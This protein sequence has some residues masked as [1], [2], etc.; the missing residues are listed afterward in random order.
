MRFDFATAARIIFGPGTVRQSATLAKELGT[1]P[2]VLTG[3]DTRRAEPLLADLRLNQLNPLTFAVCGE[4]EVETVAQGVKLAK[5]QNR[6]LVL[7][8]GGGSALDAGKAIA[9]ML[10]NEGELLDYL[11]VI[12]GAKPLA[13]PP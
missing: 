2:L 7:S 5:E 10:T 3:R 6:D 4:P 9:A 11:E 1:R 12:G 8:F 13:N